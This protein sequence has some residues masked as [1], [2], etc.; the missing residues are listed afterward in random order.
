MAKGKKIIKTIHIF[1]GNIVGR[2]KG[3]NGI[4]VLWI[5]GCLWKKSQARPIG[6]RSWLLGRKTNREGKASPKSY[7]FG[8]CVAKKK[9]HEIMNKI[10]FTNK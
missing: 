1:N 4:E 10:L 8:I 2:D 7:G 3:V 5:R 6:S 9:R